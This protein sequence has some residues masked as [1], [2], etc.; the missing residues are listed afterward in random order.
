L[1]AQKGYFDTGTRASVQIA[2]QGAAYSNLNAAIPGL[3]API[4]M[5]QKTLEATPGYQF[6]LSQGIRGVDLSSISRGSQ[7]LR[8]KPR[9]PMQRASRTRPIKTSS[10]TRTPTSR[11]PSTSCS[12][13]RR[14]ALM[15][16]GTYAAA[17]TSAGNAALGNSATVG[18]TLS[19]NAIGREMRGRVQTS[20]R[21]RTSPT[22]SPERLGS[23]PP[24]IIPS[25]ITERPACTEQ[26]DRQFSRDRRRH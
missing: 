10:I 2:Q 1:T 12:I 25:A 9:R 18:N 26:R 4:T 22:P 17:G 14:R 11:T 23:T 24:S 6:N 16:P 15:P 7:A 8:P 3:T 19:S 20:Q 5:D 13:R 21:D